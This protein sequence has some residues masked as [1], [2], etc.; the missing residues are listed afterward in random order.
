M[1]IGTWRPDLSA[2]VPLLS[3]AREG[4]SPAL[5]IPRHVYVTF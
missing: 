1:H 2:A 5:L 4:V 3:L